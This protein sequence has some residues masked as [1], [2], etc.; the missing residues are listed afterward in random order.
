MTQGM[1]ADLRVEA[2]H[3]QVFVHL[4]ADTSG[5]EASAML[6]DKQDFGIEIGVALGTLVS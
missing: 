5:A 1:R 4:A 2:G 6:I 3:F